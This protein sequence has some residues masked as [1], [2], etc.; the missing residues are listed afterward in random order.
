MIPTPVPARLKIEANQPPA[1]PATRPKINGLP[2]RRFTPKI[3]GS[4]IP[5]PAERAAGNAKALSL[6]DFVLT[7]T[8]R[9]AP[10]WAVIAAVIIALNGSLPSAAINCDSSKL[11]M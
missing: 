5:S 8:A 1:A 2:K 11:K 7:P 6:A 9:V 3:A 4:V 10:A